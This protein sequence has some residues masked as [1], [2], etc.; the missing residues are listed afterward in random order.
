M[1]IHIIVIIATIIF[2]FYLTQRKENKGTQ[3]TSTE[4]LARQGSLLYLLYVPLIIYSGYYYFVRDS[5]IP[6]LPNINSNI[7]DDLLSEPFPTTTS[8]ST[9]N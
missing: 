3:G 7:S 8:N 6:I 1:N 9:F 5:N 4:D 2:Y